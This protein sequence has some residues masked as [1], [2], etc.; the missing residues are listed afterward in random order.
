[1][2]GDAPAAAAV[3]AALAAVAPGIPA[4][5][6]ETTALNA[7]LALLY[8]TPLGAP[9][10]ERALPLIPWRGGG[11]GALRVGRRKRHLHRL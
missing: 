8:Y 3:K 4:N 6:T 2:T 7:P 5:D 9:G 10:E 1:M 11:G